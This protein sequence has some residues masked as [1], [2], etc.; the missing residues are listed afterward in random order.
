MILKTS[1]RVTAEAIRDRKTFKT[2]GGLS[3]SVMDGMGRFN[4]GHLAGEDREAFKRDA[5]HILYVVWSYSTPIA[6]WTGTVRGWYAVQQKFS[7]TTSKHQGLL[8]LI[9]RDRSEG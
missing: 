2:H 1:G 7:V 8:F 6:W 4:Y 3:A 9:P 5:P